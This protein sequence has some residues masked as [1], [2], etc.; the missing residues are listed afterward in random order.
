MGDRPEGFFHRGQIMALEKSAEIKNELSKETDP[1]RVSHLAAQKLA[2]QA[3]VFTFNKEVQ[4]QL[5]QDFPRNSV[6]REQQEKLAKDIGDKLS[7]RVNRLE[8]DEAFQL[9][10]EQL[11]NDGLAKAA[12]QDGVELMDHYAKAQQTLEARNKEGG[13]PVKEE[14]REKAKEEEIALGGDDSIHL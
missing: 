8:N 6:I 13:Q 4:A 11:G 9:M 14:V 5:K 12:G 1:K 7:G 10:C 3:S 2:I